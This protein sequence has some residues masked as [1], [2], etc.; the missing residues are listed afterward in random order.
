MRQRQKRSIAAVSLLMFYYSRELVVDGGRVCGVKFWDANKNEEVQLNANAV[1][2][3]TGITTIVRTHLRTRTC[4]C[5]STRTCK[6]THTHNRKRTCCVKT[7][8]GHNNST[9]TR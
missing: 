3:A 5:I 2:L 4:T 8:D 9:L 6:G 1:I 7:C